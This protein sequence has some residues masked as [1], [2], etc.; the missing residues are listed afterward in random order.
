VL[1]DAILR[2]LQT[3]LALVVQP[4]SP[5]VKA[6]SG[7]MYTVSDIRAFLQQKAENTA[8]SLNLLALNEL[9]FASTVD[10]VALQNELSASAAVVPKATEAA[11]AVGGVFVLSQ[12]GLALL[13]SY[14]AH[15]SDNLH[16]TD[17]HQVSA[18]VDMFLVGLCSIL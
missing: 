4:Q 8:V 10:L 6:W 3:V 16:D 5:S 13:E 11:A 1:K 9:T 14:R 2:T 18:D 12:G 15:A 17:P 7:A